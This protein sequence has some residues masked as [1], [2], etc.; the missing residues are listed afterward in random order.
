LS[1][2]PALSHPDHRLLARKV[3]EFWGGEGD[4]S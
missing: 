1:V 2:D 4:L 3:K